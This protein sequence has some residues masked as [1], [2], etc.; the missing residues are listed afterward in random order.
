MP[1]SLIRKLDD[2]SINLS[3]QRPDKNL[4]EFDLALW[5]WASKLAMTSPTIATSKFDVNPGIV[6]ALSK[7]D[8][9][10]LPNL[11]LASGVFCSFKLQS[12][13]DQILQQLKKPYQ[14]IM[15]FFDPKPYGYEFDVAYLAIVKQM[16]E[17]DSQLAAITFG[18]TNTLALSISK[19]TDS[20]LRQLCAANDRPFKYSLRFS[21][22]VLISLIKNRSHS[23]RIERLMLMKYMHS[24]S[25][26]SVINAKSGA[27]A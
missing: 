12:S 3:D 9:A 6:I 17:L 21:D 16:S 5:H 2:R 27:L 23:K 15:D 18:L 14:P 10:S 20:Q 25:N 4:F 19:A 8:P 7:I 1:R 26:V 13:E 11:G 22:N 24:M